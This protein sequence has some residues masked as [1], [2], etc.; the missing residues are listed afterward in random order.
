MFT[1]TQTFQTSEVLT[2]DDGTIQIDK[3][4]TYKPNIAMLKCINLGENWNSASGCY[5]T[6]TGDLTQ[7]GKD[8][9]DKMF[10]L[11]FEGIRL[12]MLSYL[13][14][15]TSPAF[16]QSIKNAAIY[17]LSNPKCKVLVTGCASSGATGNTGV[18]MMQRAAF[19]A[20][21]LN[22]HDFVASLNDPRAIFQAGNEESIHVLNETGVSLNFSGGILTVTFPANQVYLVGDRIRVFSNA[23]NPTYNGYYVITSVSP[24]MVVATATGKPDGVTTG[25]TVLA[26]DSFR[27]RERNFSA[28]LKARHPNTL[29]STSVPQGQDAAYIT[30]G[31]GSFD[32]IGGDFYGNDWYNGHGGVNS[33]AYF[34]SQITGW[35]AKGSDWV[36]FEWN[37]DAGAS[38]I[39]SDQKVLETSIATR[40]KM[41]CDAGITMAFFFTYNEGSDLKYAAVKKDNTPFSALSA[42]MSKYLI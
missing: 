35:R 37:L 36:I 5:N 28:I 33:D 7:T 41:L 15:S 34:N 4:V 19:E 40:Y 17:A 10:K 39:P 14:A 3:T 8:L 20:E 38:N 25:D 29:I 30:E 9:I 27:L 6:T 32:Y 16:Y 24:N 22:Y 13:F 42:L 2:V 23:L 18:N 11:G 26:L 31:K 12:N 21:M 1:K